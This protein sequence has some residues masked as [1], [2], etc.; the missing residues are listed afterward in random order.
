MRQRI[1]RQKVGLATRRQICPGRVTGQLKQVSP[2]K[3]R[4]RKCRGEHLANLLWWPTATQRTS[5]FVR[6]VP[7]MA[8][9]MQYNTMMLGTSILI[10][11]CWENL[12]KIGFDHGII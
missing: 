12:I 8:E 7:T 3:R 4:K 11:K 5:L 9:F 1:Y 2:Q 6:G 10:N